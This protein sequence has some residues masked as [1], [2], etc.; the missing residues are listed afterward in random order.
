MCNELLANLVNK[1]LPHGLILDISKKY[2]V[3]R[4]TISKFWN[5]GIKPYVEND[6]LN[7]LVFNNK[8]SFRG[9][10]RIYDP[11]ILQEEMKKIP[12]LQRTTVRATANALKVSTFTVMQLKK[13][14]TIEVCNS[15][16]RPSLQNHHK[17]A[18][19]MF[20][21]NEVNDNGTIKSM[22]DRVHIDKKN[23]TLLL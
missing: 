16:V 17:V 7:E 18:R 10:K 5:K 8:K 1:K 14:G 3:D 23:F 9:K 22:L 12:K 20:C 4:S 21:A 13:E 19:Y 2:D 15:A 6:S 11:T